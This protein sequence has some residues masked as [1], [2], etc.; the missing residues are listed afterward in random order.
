MSSAD[1]NISNDEVE[2]INQTLSNFYIFPKAFLEDITK[3]DVGNLFTESIQK[4]MESNPN[5][6]QHLLEYMIN[7][8]MSDKEMKPEEVKTIFDIGQGAF[9]YSP[10]EI[11]QIFAGLIQERFV[12]SLDSLC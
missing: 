10:T 5:Q 7:I 8:V 11:A 2:A 12:P 6:R 9:G 4:I 1:D 3:K